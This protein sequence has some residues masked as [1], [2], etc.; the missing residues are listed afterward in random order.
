MFWA[1]FSASAVSG[2]P[3]TEVGRLPDPVQRRRALG[4]FAPVVVSSLDSPHCCNCCVVC[5]Q[6]A[7]VTPLHGVIHWLPKHPR[8]EAGSERKGERELA[9]AQKW[10]GCAPV[11]MRL[12][13]L[14][15]VAAHALD[16]VSGMSTCKTVDLEI[17][18]QKRIEAIRSQILSKLRLPKAPEVDEA[19]DKEE[20]PPTLLSLYNSTKDLLKEQQTEV[21]STVSPEQ[22]EEEYFAKVLN[23]FN[24]TSEYKQPRGRACKSRAPVHPR[25]FSQMRIIT[26]GPTIAVRKSHNCMTVIYAPAFSGTCCSTVEPR[27]RLKYWSQAEKKIYSAHVW[28]KYKTQKSLT[29]TGLCLNKP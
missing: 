3:G 15:L 23:K 22:E 19:G 12:G 20:I 27:E 1:R 5:K 21:Q 6:P 9:K 2:V 14:L 24:M 11:T 7:S 4:S 13:F 17:V 18:R 26:D 16:S 10:F 25:S 28:S 8:L 29:V